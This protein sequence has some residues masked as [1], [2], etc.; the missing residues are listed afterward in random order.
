MV[1]GIFITVRDVEI[2]LG[3]ERYN[4]A[5]TYLKTAKDANKIKRRYMTIKEFCIYEELDFEYIW[6]IIRPGIEII[7]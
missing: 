4:T 1:A 7:K 2:L 3:C 5:Q 6:R